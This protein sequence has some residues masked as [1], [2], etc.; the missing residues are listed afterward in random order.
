MQLFLLQCNYDKA[1]LCGELFGSIWMLAMNW[2]DGIEF[3]N[4]VFACDSVPRSLDVLNWSSEINVRSS[5]SPWPARPSNPPCLGSTYR[6]PAIRLPCLFLGDPAPSVLCCG[7][8]RPLRTLC[9]LLR[10]S[11]LPPKQH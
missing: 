8:P 9:L 5:S 3:P 2:V 11:R 1:S 4:P 7:D 10:A 6:P